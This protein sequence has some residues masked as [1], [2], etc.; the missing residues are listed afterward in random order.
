M[1]IPLI[2]LWII[3][4]FITKETN[5]MNIE[6]QDRVLFILIYLFM[7]FII[8]SVPLIEYGKDFFLIDREEKV[9]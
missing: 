2:I 3:F 4:A 6:Q 7:L 5:L 8:I 9:Q 1:L